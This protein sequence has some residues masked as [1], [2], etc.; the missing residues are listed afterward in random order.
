[1]LESSSPR[2]NSFVVTKTYRCVQLH[3]VSIEGNEFLQ[4]HAS[5]SDLVCT[6]QI[7]SKKSQGNDDTLSQIQQC[8][9]A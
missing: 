6:K 2:S 7:S 4:A 1:M 8:Q 3:D 9:R 5:T